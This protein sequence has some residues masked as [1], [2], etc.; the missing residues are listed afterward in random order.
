M[1]VY[2][3]CSIGSG[4]PSLLSEETKDYCCLIDVDIGSVDAGVDDSAM[5]SA[6]MPRHS[7][8]ARNGFHLKIKGEKTGEGSLPIYSVRDER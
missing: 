1:G 3:F 4:N 5:W 7:I 6:R 8:L 2:R